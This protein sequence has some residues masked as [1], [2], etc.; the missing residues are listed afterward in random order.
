MPIKAVLFDL[1]NTL[2]NRSL[3]N[4]EDLLRIFNQKGIYIS[5]EEIKKAILRINDKLNN[6]LW[7]KLD[8]ERGKVP[9]SKL[10]QMWKSNFYKM[11]GI[12]TLTEKNKID[13]CWKDI[14]N[15]KV[16]P[17]VIPFLINLKS[18]RIKAGIIT[19]A[20]E[21]EVEQILKVAGLNKKF[22]D[23]IVGPDTA[24]SVKPEPK[25]F[26]Y[27]LKKLKIEPKE[28]I[29]VGDDIE[30]DYWGA[31]KIGMKSFLILRSNNK[32]IPENIRNISNLMVLNDYLD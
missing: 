29:Y 25:I 5:L 20:F 2:T 15:T 4:P 16:Y 8:E 26:L 13:L 28:A 6:D 9:H 31:K 23:I 12:N 14:S 18:R 32:K 1:D 11:L 10:Y 24:S 27:A 3:K 22:F 30:K 19:N 17:D 21:M 7:N